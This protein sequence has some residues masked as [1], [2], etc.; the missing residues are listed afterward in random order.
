MNQL[1]WRHFHRDIVLLNVR[2]YLAYPLSYRN[3]EEMMQDRGIKIDHT[4]IFR[5]VQAYSQI[6]VPNFNLK[7]RQVS[8]S[9]RMD[10]T[11]IKVGGVWR[12]LYRA[13]DKQ[14]MTVDFMLSS[15]RDTIAAANFLCKAIDVNGIPEKINIDQSGANA[16]GIELYN[17]VNG[18]KIEIRQCKYLNNIVEGDHFGLKKTLTTVTGFKRMTSAKNSIYGAEVIRMI[19]KDQLKSTGSVRLSQFEKFKSLVA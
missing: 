9:W 16:S 11:Y 15:K 17:K 10:E 12:Y 3:L 1:K 19:R 5:W 14:G 6:L 8:K 2:W 7:K 4:T 13:V 18:S